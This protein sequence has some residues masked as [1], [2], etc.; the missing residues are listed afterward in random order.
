LAL[1]LG[2]ALDGLPAQPDPQPVDDGFHSSRWPRPR[3]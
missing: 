2:R 1:V 3:H